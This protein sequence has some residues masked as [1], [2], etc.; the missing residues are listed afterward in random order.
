MSG[1]ASNPLASAAV[2]QLLQ[3]SLSS[4]I[5][6]S[7]PTRTVSPHI[8]QRCTS[9][10]K[11]TKTARLRLFEAMAWSPKH[12]NRTSSMLRRWPLHSASH[13][14]QAHYQARWHRLGIVRMLVKCEHGYQ[15]HQRLR[16][17]GYITWCA[18]SCAADSK[19]G[20]HTH[21]WRTRTRIT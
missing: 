12:T 15:L 13:L 14:F 9:V 10:S 2:F 7:D 1:S 11:V 18:L 8:G 19:C 5:R 6:A 20:F 21:R 16:S 4:R 17:V 3:P